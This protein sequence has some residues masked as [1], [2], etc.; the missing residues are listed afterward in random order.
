MTG[1]RPIV[2]RAVDARV[3]RA[4]VVV[5]EAL[6]GRRRARTGPRATSTISSPVPDTGAGPVNDG[7]SDARERH[8]LQHRLGVLEL[9]ADHELVQLAVGDRRLQRALAH[10]RHVL[11]QLLAAQELEVAAHLPGRLERVV[12]RGQVVAQKLAPASRWLSHRSS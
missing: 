8:R 3:A 10:R 6:G 11:V 1:V 2:K 9:V 5:G 12:E 7:G 4:L